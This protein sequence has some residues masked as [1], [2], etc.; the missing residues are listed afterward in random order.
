MNSVMDKVVKGPGTLASAAYERLRHEVMSA[1]VLP[2]Q[3]LNIRKLCERYEMGPSPV[4]E[5]LNRLLRDG[6]ATQADQQGFRVAPIS[7][8][9]LDELTRTRIWL[10]EI[11]LRESIAHGDAAWE[12]RVL[13]ACHRLL[14][15]PRHPLEGDATLRNEEWEKAHRIFHASLLSACR[16]QWLLAF[17]EQ[18]F[19]AA[20]RYRHVSR[21]SGQSEQRQDE[22]KQIA[23][24]TIARNAGLAVKLL[25]QH[26]QATTERARRKLE[27]LA[28]K[29]PENQDSDVAIPDGEV[30]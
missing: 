19:D 25:I 30:G 1:Q 16:S 21:I 9:Q 15:L 11:G 26:F 3:K 23:E 22:H 6:L 18:L 20:E 10:N 17:C 5:A 24:A 2:G 28:S 12:E 4:R 8:E 29:G 27:A 7:I 13:L 14:R